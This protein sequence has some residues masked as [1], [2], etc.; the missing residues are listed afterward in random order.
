MTPIPPRF[1]RAGSHPASET[2]EITAAVRRIVLY[3]DVISALSKFRLCVGCVSECNSHRVGSL[4]TV[5]RGRGQ[6]REEGDEARWALLQLKPW[7]GFIEHFFG[8]TRSFVQEF[9]FGQLIQMNK[10]IQRQEGEGFEQRVHT[11]FRLSAHPEELSALKQLP[12]R[13]DIDRACEV[14]W[15]EAAALA[16]QLCGMEIPQLPLQAADIHPHFRRENGPPTVDEEEDTEPE[17]ESDFEVA[18]YPLTA[19][20]VDFEL[21]NMKYVGSTYHRSLPKI[22]EGHR[23]SGHFLD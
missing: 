10:Q 13:A 16:T 22:P 2:T 19:T 6:S 18:S 1:N 11:R 15:K 12:P 21:L 3:G 23:P 5:D 4:E 20:D 14:G 8:V 7:S 9:T 17:W